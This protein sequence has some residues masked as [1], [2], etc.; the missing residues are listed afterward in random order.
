MHE[1]KDHMGHSTIRVTS[2]RYGHLFPSPH[3][4][5]ADSL[6]ATFQSVADSRTDERRTTLE[7]VGG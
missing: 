6:E 3:A 7:I 2:D 5:I 4:A 1:I